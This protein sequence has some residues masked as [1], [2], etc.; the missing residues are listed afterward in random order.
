MAPIE[1]HE[2]PVAPTGRPPE[3]DPGGSPRVNKPQL[4]ITGFEIF[5]LTALYFFCG[6]LGLSLAFL[7][8][9][10][11]P[12][13]PPT[14][15]ALAAILLR[16]HR[17]WPGIFLGALL[18]NITTHG[19]VATSLAIAAGNT[20]EALSGAW[21]VCRFA[22]GL[23]AFQRTQNVFRFAAFAAVPSTIV[24]ATVGVTS[25]SIAGLAPWN[26]YPAIWLTWWLGDAVSDL[27][28]APVLLIWLGP[29]PAFGKLQGKQMI[30]AFALLVLLFLVC[31][32]VFSGAARYDKTNIPYGYLSMLPILWAAFRFGQRG[33][34]ACAFLTSCAAIW[35][36][37]HD[38]GPFAMPDPNQSLLLLQ[39]FIGTITLTGLVVGAISSER[40]QAQS[41]LR[42]SET[43][44]GAVLESALDSIV[45]MG[46]DGRITDFNPA[47][48]KTFGWRRDQILG[49]TVA[50]TIIPPELREAHERGLAHFIKTG[51]GRVLG[52]RIEMIGMRADGTRFPT[53]LAI[54]VS[55]VPGHEPFFTAYL[56]DLTERKEAER[57]LEK[58]RSDLQAHAGMLET[59][60]AERTRRLNETIG[61]LEA[62]SYSLS[63]DLRGPLRA[64]ESFGRI[65][66]DENSDKLGPSATGMMKKIIGAAER[67]DRLI[68]SVLS[69]TKVS[70]AE[71]TIAPV[72]VEKLIRDI[73]GE[74]PEFQMADITLVSPLL[75]LRGDDASMTQCITNLLGNAIKFVAGGVKPKVRIYTQKL[76]EKV[77]LYFEDNGI[78]IARESQAKLFDLFHREHPEAEYEGT[79]M[80]LAIVR[81][82]VER[83]GGGVGVDSEP[84]KGS[85][86]WIELPAAE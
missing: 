48:E 40:E 39:A 7:N 64:I 69:F 82:A 66:L 60:V 23:A 77:R 24:S 81:K 19:S 9:S 29:A 42:E 33:V 30:E 84:A 20:A 61:E 62:F 73:I 74:R 63:H 10:A 70:R 12:V 31:A 47:A 65:V 16:G 8:A 25:L 51:E 14:G 80:G 22:G 17:L 26:L 56:R 27:I 55:R 32:F 11:S 58:A 37:R 2:N 35:G 86:F 41:R 59:T 15:I 52:R 71:I 28:I 49:R 50:E 75:S 53:E 21:L 54:A 3:S 36:T 68:R 45:T 78:G 4:A 5:I 44:K 76:G 79:G 43:R 13:W 67:M 46:R 57:A 6:K 34:I 85:R 72:D 1:R 38:F 18:V 83:M